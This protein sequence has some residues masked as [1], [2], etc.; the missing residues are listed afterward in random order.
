VYRLVGHNGAVSHAVFSPDGRHV[1]SGGD[2]KT[3]H[4]WRLPDAPE[5]TLKKENSP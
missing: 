1:L 5:K 4:L 3:L 2:D